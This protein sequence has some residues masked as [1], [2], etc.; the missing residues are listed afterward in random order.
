M[1]NPLTSLRNKVRLLLT[2]LKVVLLDGSKYGP[3]DY[4]RLYPENRSAR[5]AVLL[6]TMIQGQYPIQHR[7]G[8][9]FFEIGVG[10][11][12]G[13]FVIIRQS[14]LHSLNP[15]WTVSRLSFQDFQNVSS[16]N[17]THLVLLACLIQCRE[18]FYIRMKDLKNTRESKS[19]LN[20]PLLSQYLSHLPKSLIYVDDAITQISQCKAI[21]QS[22]ENLKQSLQCP[23]CD[24]CK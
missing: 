22:L 13:E 11:Y 8:I 23:Y 2:I 1:I 17:L 3:S 7:K 16:Q 18:Q 14:T 6:D 15:R 5:Q 20:C 10:V 4:E 24:D 9:S 21:K 19:L 12:Q